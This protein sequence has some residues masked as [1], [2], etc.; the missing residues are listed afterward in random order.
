MTLKRVIRQTTIE[1]VEGAGHFD[2]IVVGSGASGGLAAYKMTKAGMRVLVLDA[3]LVPPLWQ[4]PV[5]RTLNGLVKL[6]SNPIALQYLPARLTWKAREWLKLAGRHRQAVQSTCYAWEGLPD[7]FVDDLDNPY[8]TPDEQSF[9]WIRTHNIG[10]R[11]VVP[12][13]G[14]QYL[15]HS[16]S[17]FSPSDSASPKWP[18]TL[19]EM[20]PWYEEV[21]RLLQL[22]GQANG[23]EWVPDS[24]ITNDISP[25]PA[26]RAIMHAIQEKWPEAR[27][28][29]GRFADPLDSMA[30][31]AE[32][33]QLACRT[34]AMAARLLVSGD[35]RAQ[36]VE[37]YDKRER[38][39]A[40]AHAPIV[41]LCASSFET[42]RLLLNS[43]QDGAL[44]QTGAPDGPLG[45]YIMDHVSVKAEGLMPDRGMARADFDIGN[46]IYLPRFDLCSAT[47][48]GTRR[49]FGVRLYRVPGPGDHSYFT[50]V[51]DAEMLP[52]AENR[53][54]I[55]DQ[56]DRWGIPTLRI[57]YR[58]GRDEQ[59]QM[60][61][62][63]AAVRQISDMLDVRLNSAEI[64][65][66]IPGSAIHE[67]GGARMGIDPAESVVDPNNQCW[68]AKGAYVTDGAAF[69]SIGIQNPTLTI[70]ALTARA[71]AHV[72]R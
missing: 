26:Q 14:R 64:A 65:A 28:M 68:E 53:L 55:S 46:C 37:F 47:A 35:Q 16:E 48:R 4:R 49:G 6:V 59:Y 32:T 29:L 5:S 61:D 43:R 7:G 52:N 10:G 13:H 40:K 24:L 8:E 1:S 30:M 69:A 21:E 15:R 2:A 60:R 70:M 67:V 9:N 39:R 31:A 51:S 57:D 44:R 22:S 20:A 17:D 33:G 23:S 41:F 62:Q 18:V 56:R 54:T 66:S 19:A 27:P 3:G 71:C 63:V 36:G 34:G 25:G 50:A 42:T 12:G 72:T 58:L 38:R 11:M 45:R